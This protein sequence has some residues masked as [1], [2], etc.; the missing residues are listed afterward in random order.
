MVFLL[1]EKKSKMSEKISKKIQ[2]S[3]DLIGH[4]IKVMTL[5]INRRL[6]RIFD[7]TGIILA[8]NGE[9]AYVK[10]GNIAPLYIIIL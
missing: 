8:K 10:F 9:F 4:F 2:E 7:I 1:K 3:R 6:G 5:Q